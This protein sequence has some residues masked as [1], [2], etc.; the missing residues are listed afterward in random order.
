[1]A[2]LVADCVRFSSP[3]A[4]VT[5][6]CS[7]TA[8]KMR[9]CSSV[10]SSDQFYQ[11]EAEARDEQEGQCA[12]QSGTITARGEFCDVRLQPHRGQR[13]RE[14]ERGQRDDP[15]FCLPGNRHHAVDT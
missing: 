12:E 14:Q 10:M 6:W 11:C 4:R 3:A 1:M 15:D 5:C 9:S 8:M 2:A 13:D 7:A